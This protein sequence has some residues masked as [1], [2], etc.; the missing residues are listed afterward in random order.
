MD[1]RKFLTSA[2]SGVVAGSWLMASST[3]GMQA[4]EVTLP[5]GAGRVK[6]VEKG[7]VFAKSTAIISGVCR[8]KNGDLLVSFNT[9]GDL[10]SRQHTGLVRS[11]DG[12]KTWSDRPEAMFESVFKKGGIEAG[13]SLTCLSNG[14]LLLPYAD[15]FY[16]YPKQK[17]NDDRFALLFCLT[18]DDNGHTW[19]NAKAQSYDGL[20]AYAFGKVV[21]LPSGKLLL[22]LCGARDRRGTYSSGVVQS[23][24]NGDTW[25]DYRCIA[26]DRGSETPI[27]LLRDGRILALIR[28]YHGQDYDAV[29]ARDFYVGYSPDGGETWTVPQKVNMTGTSPA[30]HLTPKGLLLAGYRSTMGQATDGRCQLSSSLDN[31][32]TWEF[33]LELQLTQGQWNY[34]G[35]PAFVTLADGRILV[36]YHNNAAK[37]P[38]HTEYNILAEQ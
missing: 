25:S 20:E 10:S 24:D 14:R 32:Q 2:G 21:E 5:K 22:P 3:L 8:C 12:G 11:T 18:S 31:G 26:P 37:V 7:V 33:E 16:L 38:W 29:S 35:Y 19:Q 4:P 6:V 36:T 15:G 27:V 17:G 9:G 23:R 28:G 30:V 1:R 34:G 13:C